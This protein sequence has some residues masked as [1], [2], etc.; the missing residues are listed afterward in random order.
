MRYKD[1]LRK[2]MNDSNL[3]IL[4]TKQ[5]VDSLGVSVATASRVLDSLIEIGDLVRLKRGLYAHRDCSIY[6]IATHINYPHDSYVSL[7]SALAHHGIYDQLPLVMTAV[8]KGPSGVF[9]TPKG[10]IELHQIDPKLFGGFAE[11]KHFKLASKEKAFL[12]LTYFWMKK[13]LRQRPEVDLDELRRSRIQELLE[14]FDDRFQS[15]FS[16]NILPARSVSLQ[17]I[18]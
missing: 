18:A 17:T 2:Q 16:R 11:D 10:R 14:K 8:T 6:E 9:H 7:Q 4:T 15:Y 3:R 12:D 1:K 5:V 13:G